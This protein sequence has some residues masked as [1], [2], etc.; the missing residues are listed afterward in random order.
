MSARGLGFGLGMGVVLEPANAQL[1]S[2]AGSFFWGG[3]ASTFFN[4]DPA[5]QTVAVVMTQVMG[6]S[7]RVEIRLSLRRMVTQAIV[8]EPLRM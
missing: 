3:M 5:Q 8:S 1:A 7:M 4:I 2:A 6:G